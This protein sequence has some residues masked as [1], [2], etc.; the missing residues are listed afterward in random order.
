MCRCG[1]RIFSH[2]PSAGTSVRLS[3]RSR[4]MLLGRDSLDFSSALMTGQSLFAAY[5]NHGDVEQCR[6]PGPNLFVC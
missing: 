6:Q 4:D 5:L 3:V 2:L 1:R